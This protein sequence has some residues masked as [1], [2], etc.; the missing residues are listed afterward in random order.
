MRDRAMEGEGRKKGGE[1]GSGRREIDSWER[2]IALLKYQG[3][4]R[5]TSSPD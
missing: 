2:T 1:Q 4:G 3:V 5:I